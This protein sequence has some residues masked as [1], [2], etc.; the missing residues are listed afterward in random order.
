M[1]AIFHFP[2]PRSFP[3]EVQGASSSSQDP[4]QPLPPWH[5]ASTSRRRTTTSPTTCPTPTRPAG[6]GVPAATPRPP[7]QPWI[8]AIH[9]DIRNTIG[10]GEKAEPLG[11]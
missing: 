6:P 8:L 7:V 2:L 5:G 11:A 3:M 4:T 9:N 10:P 1:A